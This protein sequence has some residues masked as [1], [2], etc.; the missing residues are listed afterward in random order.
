MCYDGDALNDPYYV[1]YVDGMNIFHDPHHHIMGGFAHM[2]ATEAHDYNRGYH[3]GWT[4]A[5]YKGWSLDPE[6]VH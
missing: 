6:C 1:G 5:K 4:D 3:D 2:N